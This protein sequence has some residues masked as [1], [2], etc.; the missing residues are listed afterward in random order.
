MDIGEEYQIDNVDETNFDINYTDNDELSFGESI[1][2]NEIND[3]IIQNEPINNEIN[4]EIVEETIGGEYPD[5]TTSEEL[6]SAY[7]TKF[8]I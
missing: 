8:D 6:L 1:I 4:N 2:D 5:E 3:N 7:I